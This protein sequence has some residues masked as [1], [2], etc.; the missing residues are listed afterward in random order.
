MEYKQLLDSFEKTVVEA[1]EE[2]YRLCVEEWDDP[3][4]GYGMRDKVIDITEKILM[5]AFT[6]DYGLHWYSFERPKAVRIECY[7]ETIH[8]KV[9]LYY[10]YNMIAY[11]NAWKEQ[12]GVRIV[13][14]FFRG[15]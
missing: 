1:V 7:P 14:D 10:S 5:N 13:S 9:W 11:F 12:D 15:V 3:E 2:L 8:V 4:A 6:Y